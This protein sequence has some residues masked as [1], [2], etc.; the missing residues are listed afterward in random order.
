MIQVVLNSTT[1]SAVQAEFGGGASGA[2]KEDTIWQFLV[3]NNPEK[4]DLAKA[5]DNFTRSCAGYCVA[6][7]VLGIGDRHNG[8]IMVTNDGYLFHIDFGHF[9]G[10]FKSK[11]GINRERSRFVFT[12]EM[13]F[14]MGGS[15]KISGSKHPYKV[16][17][18][19]C[20]QAIELVRQ[21]AHEI[22]TLFLTMIGAGMPELTVKSSILYIRDKLALLKTSQATKELF[23]KELDV[24][25]NCTSRTWDNFMHNLKHR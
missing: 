25:I 15:S 10:N 21:H 6:T 18:E 5:V 16:F 11:L 14:A 19:Y 1:T 20:V 4:D 12:K 7:Y 9:L 22:E 23:L 24:A 8:N 13:A 3:K 17:V 2:F